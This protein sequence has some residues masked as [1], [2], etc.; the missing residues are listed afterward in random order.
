[1]LS[2]AGAADKAAPLPPLS[3]GSRCRISA[4]RG[5]P[6]VWRVP[7]CHCRARSVSSSHSLPQSRSRLCVTVLPSPGPA[8]PP[9]SSGRCWPERCRR[10]GGFRP[11]DCRTGRH[12]RR[13]PALRM[14]AA[15]IWSALPTF[16]RLCALRPRLSPDDRR[17]APPRNRGCRLR[18]VLRCGLKG[19]PRAS[20]ALPSPRR[21]SGAGRVP[22]RRSPIRP[23]ACLTSIGPKTGGLR[24]RARRTSKQGRRPA[25]SG[26]LSRSTTRSRSSASPIRVRGAGG[27]N[28]R[29]ASSGSGPRR[30]Q[31]SELRL[32]PG[33]EGLEVPRA[34]PQGK[35]AAR[36]SR[37]GGVAPEGD[38]ADAAT[39]AAGGRGQRRGRGSC[40]KCSASGRS[41]L[42]DPA[43]RLLHRRRPAAALSARRRQ[44][45]AALH[46]RLVTPAT[47]LW[48]R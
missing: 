33:P 37:L 15:S 45:T 36:R 7:L 20:N 1:M 5:G 23:I 43:A 46:A 31:P 9:G 30:R 42:A 35:L 28:Q 14:D 40:G 4:D 26:R 16:A 6:A 2:V 27:P 11:A 34:A 24:R 25:A 8:P 17:A 3:A 29:R 18:P 13:C 38:G 21:T 44:P 39:R 10:R 12:A 32:P 22:L 48:S 47:I 41:R 19:G